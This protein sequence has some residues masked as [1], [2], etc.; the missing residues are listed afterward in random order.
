MASKNTADPM[1]P[2][3]PKKARVATDAMVIA[4]MKSRKR[5]LKL[6]LNDVMK[7]NREIKK[8]LCFATKKCIINRAM[9]DFNCGME[10]TGDKRK[11]VYDFMVNLAKFY[12]ISLHCGPIAPCMFGAIRSASSS[13][14]SGWQPLSWGVLVHP[15][16]RPHVPTTSCQ[17]LQARVPAGMLWTHR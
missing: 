2:P 16:P 3:T 7:E 11:D 4:S 6:I 17:T 12:I 10:M 14:T 15:H 8:G 5:V 1:V 9:D 13:W